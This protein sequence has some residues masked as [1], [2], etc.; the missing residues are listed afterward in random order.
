[1]STIIEVRE[2]HKFDYEKLK[3]Y[4]ADKIPEFASPHAL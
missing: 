2:Q 3:T 4:L 1:M